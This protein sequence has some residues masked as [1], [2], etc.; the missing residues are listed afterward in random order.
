MT[1]T[2]PSPFQFFL[3]G[4]QCS[5]S[6]SHPS[7]LPEAYPAC[8]RRWCQELRA[9]TWIYAWHLWKDWALSS[10]NILDLLAQTSP[11]LPRC[12]VWSTSV[13]NR[14]FGDISNFCRSGTICLGYWV[15]QLTSRTP[16]IFTLFLSWT[17]LYSA[18]DFHHKVPIG[19]GMS[20]LPGLTL[21]R[22][23]HHLHPN[24]RKYVARQIQW[25]IV[26]RPDKTPS[27]PFKHAI[28]DTSRPRTRQAETSKSITVFWD[29]IENWMSLG[30]WICSMLLWWVDIVMRWSWSDVV[31]EQRVTGWCRQYGWTRAP[32]YKCCNYDMLSAPNQAQGILSVWRNGSA[33]SPLLPAKG[34][35]PQWPWVP[36]M[37][38]QRFLLEDGRIHTVTKTESNKHPRRPTKLTRMTAENRKTS[39]TGAHTA[40]WHG[41]YDLS[42]FQTCFT[43]P[44][45]RIHFQSRL[46]EPRHQ[47]NNNVFRARPYGSAPAIWNQRQQ[48]Q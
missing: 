28:M 39:V 24:P 2:N 1:L 21:W 38:L 23:D 14:D 41:Q 43:P 15:H 16:T 40:F 26:Q 3:Q 6:T 47:K 27:D 18:C 45:R 34:S 17:L 35:N 42:K 22:Q 20:C 37:A 13:W 32:I 11:S 46:N 36:T 25:E 5:H 19:W 31:K 30:L 10:Q 7:Y 8:H 33:A 48:S 12:S 44:S 4:E 9:N 29:S